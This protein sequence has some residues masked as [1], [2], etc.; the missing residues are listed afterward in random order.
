MTT[1]AHTVRALVFRV[2]CALALATFLANDASGQD[3]PA[4]VSRLEDIVSQE[5]A[6]KGFPSFALVVVDREGPIADVAYGTTG[7]D[8]GGPITGSTLFRTGSVGK[9][10]TD[11]A[12]MVAVENGRL[13]LDSDVRRYLP[14]FQPTNP[15]DAPITLRQLMTHVAGLVR[16]PPVGNYFDD[17]SPTLEE[18]VRSLNTTSLI[19]APGSR[20]KYS[21]AGL[22]VVGRV[23]EVVYGQSYAAV[24]R[25]LVFEPARMRT[26]GVGR[27]SVQGGDVAMGVMQRPDGSTWA[28][29]VFDLGMSPAGDLYA[30]MADMASFMVSLLDGEGR[31][32]M[33]RTLRSMWTPSPPRET[34]QLDVGLGFSLNGRF[35]D[36]YRMARNGGAVYGFATELA[37]LPEEG[38]GVYAVASRDLANPTVQAVAHWALL[39]ALAERRGDAAPSYTSPP[40]PF[41]DLR[42]RVANCSSTPNSTET[43][44]AGTYGE[45]HNPLVVC[46][47]EGRLYALI[48]WMFLYPLE[49]VSDGVFTFP[50]YAL[51]GHEQLRF[52]QDGGRVSAAMLGVGQEGIRFAR[53]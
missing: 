38:F 39:A 22:A 44:F 23:L 46:H 27:A 30:S 16:E 12:V 28:A 42:S 7:I 20:T 53:R 35:A 15:F 31:V 52:L 3:R 1:F 34:W 50:S 5:A 45:D 36:Q 6:T 51:Y 4:W 40:V 11:L 24:L 29:P 33:S 48:E 25:Q 32:A 17:T 8:G 2:A 49:A 19:W 9:T 21:N 47:V 37:L 13:D 43:R 26:A 14:D 18:T 41:D 10:L